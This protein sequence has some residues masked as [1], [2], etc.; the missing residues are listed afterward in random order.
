MDD[1]ISG[2]SQNRIVHGG[3]LKNRA[4]GEQEDAAIPPIQIKLAR[5][6]LQDKRISAGSCGK[7]SASLF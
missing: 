2:F 6:M 7:S 3:T 4:G 1:G 5:H